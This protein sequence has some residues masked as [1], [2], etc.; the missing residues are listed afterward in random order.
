MTRLIWPHDFVKRNDVTDVS[1]V[2]WVTHV[3]QF[4]IVCLEAEAESE[5]LDN[6]LR[7]REIDP[8]FHHCNERL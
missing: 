7:D 4:A 8:V 1:E 5:W 6:D 3:C 2:S